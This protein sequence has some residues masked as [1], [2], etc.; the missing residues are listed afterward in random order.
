[1]G[2]MLYYAIPTGVW[3]IYSSWFIGNTV[4]YWITNMPIF[5]P[6]IWMKV[7]IVSYI[8]IQV[9]VKNQN[10]KFMEVKLEDEGNYTC[11][12]QNAAGKIEFTFHVLV[13]GGCYCKCFCI[14]CMELF[15]LTAKLIQCRFYWMVDI[16]YISA[17]SDFYNS[18]CLM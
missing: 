2:M 7:L 17:D 13:E 16:N 15:R 4:I 5:I 1:M 8:S 6:F 3:S 18:V 10:L 14:I 9:R 11:V 12:A